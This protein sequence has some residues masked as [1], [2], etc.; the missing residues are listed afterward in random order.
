MYLVKRAVLGQRVIA[1][2]NSIN[3]VVARA[4]N[5]HDFTPKC[6]KVQGPC[7]T[8]HM[9]HDHCTMNLGVGVSMSILCGGG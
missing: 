4:P 8:P 5:G 6:V 9:T 3:G 2:H 7:W 1:P